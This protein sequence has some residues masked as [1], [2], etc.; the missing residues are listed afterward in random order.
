MKKMFLI[1]I[2]ILIPF[3]RCKSIDSSQIAREEFYQYFNGHNDVVAYESNTMF[4]GEKEINLAKLIPN[5]EPCGGIT[6]YNECLFFCT[7]SDISFSNKNFKIYS[8]DIKSDDIELL[9]TKS[10]CGTF[11][12]TVV[13]GEFIYFLYHLDSQFNQNSKQLYRYNIID[14]ICEKI[15]EGKEADLWDY[16]VDQESYYDIK[17]V[18]EESNNSK[19]FFIIKNEI[20]GEERTIDDE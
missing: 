2:I 3:L 7:S 18:E 6:L 19:H 12:H 11:P 16:K 9:F 14:G 5:E 17:I 15:A 10:D 20:T 8:Y 13:A 4:L 1:L